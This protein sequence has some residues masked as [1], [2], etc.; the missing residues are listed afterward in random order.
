MPITNLTVKLPVIKRDARTIMNQ[1]LQKGE[2]FTVLDFESLKKILKSA[3]LI[4]STTDAVRDIC[5]GTQ[6]DAMAVLGAFP[7]MCTLAGVSSKTVR[8][9]NA[10]LDG[11]AND[12]TLKETN[13]QWTK[14]TDLVDALPAKQKAFICQKYQEGLVAFFKTQLVNKGK[15]H[16][17]TLVRPDVS[18]AMVAT[19]GSSND[20]YFNIGKCGS[21]TI[22]SSQ[23]CNVFL[24]VDVPAAATPA[25][26]DS[27]AMVTLAGYR[28]IAGYIGSQRAAF[29]GHV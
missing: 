5:Q 13:T 6:G 2:V 9:I 27:L 18:H 28:D 20:G 16:K 22:L 15:T 25:E 29:G 26:I 14:F 24:S 19:D 21:T 1:S 23:H 12:N 17:W 7:K 10:Q 3:H 4:R 11:F 8:S